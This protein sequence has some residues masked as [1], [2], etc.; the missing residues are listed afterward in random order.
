MD[1]NGALRRRRRHVS[2]NDEVVSKPLYQFCFGFIIYQQHKSDYNSLLLQTAYP[3]I[4]PMVLRSFFSAL[5]FLRTSRLS[6]AVYIFAQ[7]QPPQFDLPN[8][9]KW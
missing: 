8:T 1:Q 2:L 7:S 5:N 6:H 9:H 3:S 4:Y